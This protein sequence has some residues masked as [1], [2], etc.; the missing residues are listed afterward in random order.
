M[1]VPK[2]M[3]VTTQR[4]PDFLVHRLIMLGRLGGNPGSVGVYLGNFPDFHPGVKKFEGMLFGKKIAWQE[5]PGA[6]GLE[7]LCEHPL[8][9]GFPASA[10]VWIVADDDA[11]LAALRRVAE[12]MRVVKERSHG[13]NNVPP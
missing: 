3:V 1:T 11:R 10:H 6:K 2:G 9:E 8:G 4:G 12:S 13:R 5:M 7:T